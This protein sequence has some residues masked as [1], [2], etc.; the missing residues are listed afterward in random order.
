MYCADHEVAPPSCMPLQLF[1]LILYCGR[2]DAIRWAYP[3]HAETRPVLLS[4]NARADL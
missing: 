1:T 2:S 3:L 4:S